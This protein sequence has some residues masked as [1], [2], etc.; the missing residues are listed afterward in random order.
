VQ[1][2]AKQNRAPILTSTK[3]VRALVPLTE[4]HQLSR[5]KS[6]KISLMLLTKDIFP[7]STKEITIIM[8]LMEKA[9]DW[10]D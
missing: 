9:L 1:V 2:F 7:I 4:V 3:C 5:T 6:S 10:Q 8:A